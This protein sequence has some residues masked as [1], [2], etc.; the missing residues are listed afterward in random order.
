MYAAIEVGGLLGSQ[1]GGES[2][3]SLIDGPYLRN[4]TID[5]HAVQV[6]PAAPGTVYIATQVAMFRGRDRGRHWEHVQI[7]EM[8]PGGSYCRDL[9]VAPDDPNVLYLAAGAGGGGA[10]AGTSE[11][12]ALFRSRD[13][14][15]TW[16]RV[17]IGDVPPSRMARIAID[18]RAPALVS[19]LRH[20]RAGLHQPG[21]RAGLDEDAGPGR[22][23]AQPAHLPDGLRLR[24]GSD[25]R[26]SCW[27][28]GGRS[29]VRL[30][31]PAQREQV[32]EVHGA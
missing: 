20:A 17:D 9:L 5:L 12:G 27:V 23:L 8:F 19:L 7:G 18:R 29:D 6:S 30:D 1:D 15:E 10:P 26:A 32:E 24:G 22:A 25:W 2:W 14:G 3:T 21:R 4:N 28:I 16:E 31:H 11:A 13:T